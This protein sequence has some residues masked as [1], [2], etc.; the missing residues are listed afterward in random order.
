MADAERKFALDEADRRLLR[1]LQEDGRITNQELAARCNMSPS[2]CLERMRKLRERG[3]ILGYAALL[4]PERLGQPLLVFVEVVLDRTTGDVFR[5]FAE[6][7]RQRPEVLEC[8][9]VAGGFDYLLKL[10]MADMGAYRIFL[11]ETLSEMPGVRETRTYPVMENVKS[12]TAI[13]I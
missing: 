2:S 4:D 7:V 6:A 3:F 9:M 13:S 5:Q 10:R 11:A 8:H 1:I 12:T